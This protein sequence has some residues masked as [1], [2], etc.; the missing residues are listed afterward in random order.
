VPAEGVVVSGGQVA[1]ALAEVVEA[2]PETPVRQTPLGPDRTTDILIVAT[3]IVLFAWA[4]ANGPLDV[5]VGDLLTLAALL[6]SK[7][8]S[9]IDE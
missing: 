5:G 9:G 2:A 4:R 8:R 6:Y 3:V 1:V 7:L